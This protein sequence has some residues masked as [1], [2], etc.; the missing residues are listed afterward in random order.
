MKNKLKQIYIAIKEGLSYIKSKNNNDWITPDDSRYI[1]I[2]NE[3]EPKLQKVWDDAKK[4]FTDKIKTKTLDI[5]DSLEDYDEDI[6]MDDGD[7]DY[8]DEALLILAQAFGA[9]VIVGFEEIVARGLLVEIPAN[10]IN[11]LDEATEIKMYALAALSNED[12][13][14]NQIYE[15]YNKLENGKELI[16][17]WFDNNSYRLTDMILGGLVWYGIN[18]GFAKAALNEDV[19][20]EE[21]ALNLYWLT[22]QDKKV[23]GDC[24]KMENDNPYNKENPLTTLPGGGKTLCGSRCRC[25]ID[26]KERK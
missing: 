5:D 21:S 8:V 16:S 25:V 1:N 11:L 15:S 2:L 6:L 20:S 4:R 22:E 7:S 9:G 10:P 19:D 23:C 18:F 3:Y 24:T 26:T 17:Q 12:L 13:Q 14:M